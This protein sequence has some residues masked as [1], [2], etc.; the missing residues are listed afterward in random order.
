MCEF[1]FQDDYNVAF[2][3]EMLLSNKGYNLFEYQEW[4]HKN[5]TE[6]T[7]GCVNLLRFVHAYCVLYVALSS[8]PARKHPAPWRDAQNPVP[9]PSQRVDLVDSTQTLN[10]HLLL[11]GLSVKS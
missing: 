9:L 10:I 3:L 7:L 4:Q 2:S 6:E 1:L 11:P 5:K 8:V